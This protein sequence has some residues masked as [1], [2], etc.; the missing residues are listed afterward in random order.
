MWVTVSPFLILSF[1]RARV[2]QTQE[3]PRILLEYTQTV[4][5]GQ[6][7]PP[8]VQ[9]PDAK[10]QTFE[11]KHSRSFWI[12]PTYTVADSKSPALLSASRNWR[13]FVEDKTD[14]F[15]LDSVGFE[16]G[17]AQASNDFPGS[18]QRAAWCGQRFGAGLADE[19]A[20]GFWCSRTNQQPDPN[21]DCQTN[22]GIW[23][24]GHSDCWFLFGNNRRKSGIS[25][26][27]QSSLPLSLIF[28]RKLII[29]ERSTMP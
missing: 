12:F 13:M 18:G 21:C 6:G 20:G 19:A 26:I 15:T 23:R 1:T 27:W 17:L 11:E 14:P 28:L 2:C 25:F 8:L 3:V 24:N 16:A 9:A 7:A 10:D 22:R 4:S 29:E 5:P